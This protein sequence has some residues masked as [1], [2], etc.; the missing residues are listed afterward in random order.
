MLALA[1]HVPDIAEH[2]E[3]A[4]DRAREA[5]HIVGIAGHEAGGEAPGEM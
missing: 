2:E 3:I 5:R 1:D 4:G